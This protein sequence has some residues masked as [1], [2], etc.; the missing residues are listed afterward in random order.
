MD[1][2]QFFIKQVFE[3]GLTPYAPHKQTAASVATNRVLITDVHESTIHRE[4]RRSNVPKRPPYERSKTTCAIPL[5]RDENTNGVVNGQTCGKIPTGTA[6]QPGRATTGYSIGGGGSYVGETEAPVVQKALRRLKPIRNDLRALK[7]DP[8]LLFP[9]MNTL[10]IDGSESQHMQASQRDHRE[11]KNANKL[12]VL[13][14]RRMSVRMSIG[15]EL[16]KQIK[17]VQKITSSLPDHLMAS[18]SKQIR[19][20]S[21]SDAIY[22][23]KDKLLKYNKELLIRQVVLD[24]RWQELIGSLSMTRGL[25]LKWQKSDDEKWIVS[26]NDADESQENG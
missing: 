19:Q 21:N 7:E 25:G 9:R 18:A 3:K 13:R 17:L 14:D 26:K 12:S 10:I 2:R 15:E 24:P 16:S 8:S 20:M 6:F 11:R 22:E 5:R 23:N 1:Q 4:R